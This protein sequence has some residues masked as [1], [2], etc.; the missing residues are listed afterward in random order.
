MTVC[1][2][3]STSSK[4]IRY[5]IFCRNTFR[6]SLKTKKGQIVLNYLPFF[7]IASGVGG[8]RT[9]VQT[10]KQYAFYTFSLDLVFEWMLDQGHRHTP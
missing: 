5:N 10:R 6:E 7:D 3:K 1:L 2:P 4:D 8:I 9:L